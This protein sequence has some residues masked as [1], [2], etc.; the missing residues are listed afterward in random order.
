LNSKNSSLVSNF[1]TP[2]A[3]RTKKPS[4]QPNQLWNFV[5]ALVPAHNFWQVVT[6][7]TPLNF[8]H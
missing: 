8:T 2:L 5:G 3:T 1:E 6:A 7:F 4:C